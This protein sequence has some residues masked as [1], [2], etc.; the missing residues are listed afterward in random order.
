MALKIPKTLQEK[1]RARAKG[2]C[3]YCL[4][5]LTS[6]GRVTIRTLGLNRERLKLI[7]SEDV[8]VGRH[9]PQG[10]LLKKY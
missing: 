7:R 3:E 9:P 4:L 5:P 10:D 2:L 1:V 6:I 8:V